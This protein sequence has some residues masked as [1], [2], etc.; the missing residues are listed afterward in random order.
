M[1]TRFKIQKQQAKPF[2][3]G[4]I[5]SKYT[6]SLKSKVESQTKRT[7]SGSSKSTQTLKNEIGKQ[8]HSVNLELVIDNKPIKISKFFVSNILEKFDITRST[9]VYNII[10]TLP[11]NIF[12]KFWNVTDKKVKISF[13]NKKLSK[14]YERELF[15]VD[16][17]IISQTRDYYTVD[18]VQLEDKYIRLLNDYDFEKF[19][20]KSQEEVQQQIQQKHS[21]KFIGSQDT[22]VPH[23]E[24]IKFQDMN[25][26]QF[27]RILTFYAINKQRNTLYR[28][29]V[30]DNTLF[31]IH[32][33]IQ[34]TDVII[35]TTTI[36]SISSL[37]SYERTSLIL[38][39]PLFYKYL[40]YNVYMND[41]YTYDVN[42]FDDK[43]FNRLKSKNSKVLTIFGDYDVY[44][45]EIF[46]L[47]SQSELRR[48]L[49]YVYKIKTNN[50]QVDT[51]NLFS[52][53]IVE[54]PYTK[55]KR[56]FLCVGYFTNIIFELSERVSIEQEIYVTPKK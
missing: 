49:R 10:L 15:V 24:I 28:Q 47:Q 39:N 34:K 23:R 2:G 1:S 27:L 37:E 41:K 51:L 14:L 33:G 22:R 9:P 45:P 13:E 44:Y 7:L 48:L 38:N 6:G 46:E 18:I 56:E 54:D 50:I 5:Y 35:P 52:N 36:D 42:L 40:V 32:Q 53:V 17:Y 3:G 20:N 11:V 19:E 43:Y 29:F 12:E 31:F 26:V 16:I 55:Q 21:L 25:Q 30:R 4:K 8:T